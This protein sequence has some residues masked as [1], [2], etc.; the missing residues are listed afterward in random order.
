[1][2]EKEAVTSKNKARY[3]LTYWT[4]APTPSTHPTKIVHCIS[5]CVNN[6]RTLE[7][8]RDNWS[9]KLRP[10]LRCFGFEF[11]EDMIDLRESLCF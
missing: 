7:K 2:L 9:P 10:R 8:S 4:F 11:M 3:W 1:M 5:R 6:S